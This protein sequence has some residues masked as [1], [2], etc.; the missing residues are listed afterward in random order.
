MT[1]KSEH[2]RRL[3]Q[4]GV[5]PRLMQIGEISVSAQRVVPRVAF[6]QGILGGIAYALDLYAPAISVEA[7][8]EYDPKIAANTL[9]ALA[10]CMEGYE[11]VRI[12]RKRA[13]G[14]RR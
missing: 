10:N 13:R 9:R 7:R 3:T 14:K 4:R 12:A 1:S 5:S 6:T 8:T 2:K 11:F